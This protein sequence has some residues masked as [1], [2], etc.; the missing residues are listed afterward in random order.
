MCYSHVMIQFFLYNY[1]LYTQFYNFLHLLLLLVVDF[2]FITIL[3]I[4]CIINCFFVCFFYKRQ[5]NNIMYIICSPTTKYKGP[6]GGVMVEI[7]DFLPQ[8]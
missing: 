3:F 8:V 4:T 5:M 6:R 1:L 7:F 2:L